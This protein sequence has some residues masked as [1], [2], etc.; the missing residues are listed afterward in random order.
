MDGELCSDV[1]LSSSTPTFISPPG[2]RWLLKAGRTFCSEIFAALSV[3]GL[4]WSAQFPDAVESLWDLGI[5]Y[6]IN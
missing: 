4:L 6:K 5:G 1:F 2:A 3:Q